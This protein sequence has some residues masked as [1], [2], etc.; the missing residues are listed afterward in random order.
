MLYEQSQM[1]VAMP[2][3]GIEWRLTDHVSQYRELVI[4]FAFFIAQSKYTNEASCEA[5]HIS[6]WWRLF[7]QKDLHPARPLMFL[8]NQFIFRHWG[9]GHSSRLNKTFREQPICPTLSPFV[10]EACFRALI[11]SADGISFEAPRSWSSVEFLIPLTYCR[12]Y[13]PCVRGC[14]IWLT[15]KIV[16]YGR[17]NI[18]GSA[19]RWKLWVPRIPVTTLS[20]YRLGFIDELAEVDQSSL[21]TFPTPYA[22]FLSPRTGNPVNGVHQGGDRTLTGRCLDFRVPWHIG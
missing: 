9:C 16:Q 19:D 2:M 14:L 11:L 6:L 18:R 20:K 3:Y 4:H 5:L 1:S 15:W 10:L 7:F 8:S 21:S 17:H 13:Q 22:T 12:M